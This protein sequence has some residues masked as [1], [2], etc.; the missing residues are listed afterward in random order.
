M[1]NLWALGGEII[2]LLHDTPS[3]RHVAMADLVFDVVEEGGP[4]PYGCD[5]E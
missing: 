1:N 4:L 2:S 5:S 3:L